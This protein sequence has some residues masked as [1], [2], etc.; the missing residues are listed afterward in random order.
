[1]QAAVADAKVERDLAELRDIDAARKRIRNGKYGRCVDCG[2]DIDL[3][4]IQTQPDA[5]RC[6]QC[7]LRAE[8][9]S[10]SRIFA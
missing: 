8:R 4:R 6:L 7:Q 1:M 5:C 9:V 10:E 3:G 2:A